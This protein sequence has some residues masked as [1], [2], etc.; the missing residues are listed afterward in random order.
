MRFGP[1]NRRSNSAR[2]R[3][4]HRPRS[5]AG[6]TLAETL[7]ALLFLAIV[8]P[9]AVHGIQLASYAGQVSQRK[10]VAARIAERVIAE[11]LASTS[12]TA[13][14]ASGTILE[15]AIEYRWQTSSE[16]WTDA[17]LRLF[18]VEVLFDVQGREHDVR[19]STLVDP[20]AM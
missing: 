19:V 7:A 16:S 11:S 5:R 15:G 6:F 3:C 18:T 9:V 14:G 2:V 1:T 12:G 20:A 8:I 17:N 10:T 13:I 4:A